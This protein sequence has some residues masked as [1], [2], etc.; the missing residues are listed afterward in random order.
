MLQGKSPYEILF[1][2]PPTYDLLRTFGCLCYAHHR[3][4]DND[5]FGP[6]S[7]KCI[8]VGYP[9][10]KKGWRVYD[11]ETEQFF[12]SR[13]VQ[14]QE[15]VFP[16]HTSKI[17]PS[18]PL[19]TEATVDDDWAVPPALFTPVS[20][21]S[22]VIELDHERE[23]DPVELPTP[24]D[25]LPEP[26]TE[27]SS[28]VVASP[29]T[30]VPSDQDDSPPPSPGLPEL[31]GRGH[32]SKKTS[33]LLKDFV[34]QNVHYS[35][36][37]AL[38]LEPT[39]SKSSKTVS[40]KTLYPL[41]NYLSDSDFTA[42]H[43]AFM[44]AVLDSD[45]PRHFK[46]AIR[47]KEWCE[48]MKKEIEALEGNHTWD[49]VD[50][51]PGKTAIGSKWVYKLKFNSDGSL[52]RHKARLVAMGNRQQESVDFKETFA[53]VAK[54]TTVRHLLAVAAAKDWEVHQMDVHNAFL[55]GD[56]EE[57]MY[58][59]LPPGFQSSDPNK[60]C[61]LRKSLYGLKQAPRCWF[62]KLSTALKDYG[63]KQGYPDYSLFSLIQDGTILHVLVYVD[64]FVIAGNDLSV[65]QK[66]KEYLHQCFHMKDLGKLK[67]FLGI[68][69]SRGPDGIC[70]SQRKYA[71]DIIAEAGL[72]G[73]KL[74]AVPVE[75]NHK[76]GSVD[77]PELKRPKEYRRLVDSTCGSLE[78]A[79]RVVRYLKGSPAQG[80]LLRR[81]SDLTITAYCDSDYNACLSRSLS[82]FIVYLGDSPISWRTKKQDTESCS[83]AEAEYRS[84]AY[85]LR[86]LKWLK[87]LLHTFGYDHPHPMPLFC[88]SQ[89]ALHIA[90]NPVFHERT[91][92]IESD[93][94]QVRDAV[95][96][97]LIAT[98]HIS[99]KE[100]VA[101]IFTKAL[102][103]TLFEKLVSKLGVRNI[104][105]P[106]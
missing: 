100:Q 89:A 85:T 75:V 52:E 99:T 11:L 94:H 12:V 49:I 8:F 26:P 17:E 55:H 33:I 106:T 35:P 71:L 10:G 57:E 15:N 102:S 38:S 40:G 84:M 29:A 91:K 28:P 82:A 93:C 92:L 104:R 67:Y 83:S 101:D 9:Y 61:R 81:D 39:T 95:Q 60:V 78:A 51:P 42:H 105:P 44:A 103:K 20:P 72:L 56:L 37:H 66:F 4:C 87:A 16:F 43:I 30:D 23:P 69:V 13:D 14:F 80:I 73:A 7:R 77:S 6:R 41:T 74:S 59:K 65:I 27:I 70:L 47:I 86:E 79:L 32:R 97:G 53:S 24:T 46:D 36:S 54:L 34:T 62:A 18:P 96:D 48:A 90:A 98:H 31:L 68:E 3:A 50:L 45:E 1:E 5:K 88:D 19:Q 58:M 63:F 21:I 25:P 2:K 22:P 64:D 76:L